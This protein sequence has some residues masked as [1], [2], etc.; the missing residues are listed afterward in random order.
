MIQS[1]FR[2]FYYSAWLDIWLCLSD[3]SIV[4][5]TR[6]EYFFISVRPGMIFWFRLT[7]RISKDSIRSIYSR[8]S[9]AIPVRPVFFGYIFSDIRSFKI[10]FN[11][12]ILFDSGPSWN[13]LY[14][15][16]MIEPLRNGFYSPNL[17]SFVILSI[18]PSPARLFWL[19]FTDFSTV[20]SIVLILFDSRTVSEWFDFDRLPRTLWI[21]FIRSISI[22]ACH[23]D[24]ARF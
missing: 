23:S 14:F 1:T 8:F 7:P 5:C 6:L 20:N 17:L 15:D 12:K 11:S 2:S 22:F 16:S 9:P 3:F 4:G 21:L 10:L 18:I 19:Q 13:N 24:P